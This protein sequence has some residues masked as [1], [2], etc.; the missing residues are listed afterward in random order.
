MNGEAALRRRMQVYGRVISG[1]WWREKHDGMSKVWEVWETRYSVSPSLRLSSYQNNMMLVDE[2]IRARNRQGRGASSRVVG[3][4]A[5]RAY[6]GVSRHVEACV[7]ACIGMYRHVSRHAPGMYRAYTRHDG[8]C[9]GQAPG[10][11][12]AYTRH[13][14]TCSGHGWTCRRHGRSCTGVSSHD[15]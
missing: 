10:M 1:S 12:Q 5:C 15:G 9:T 8:T 13:D 11:Y 14:R 4:E 2:S 6:R 7:E 3:L